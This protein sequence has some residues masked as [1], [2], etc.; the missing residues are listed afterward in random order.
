M[1]VYAC[2]C[3][4]D[5]RTMQKTFVTSVILHDIHHDCQNSFQGS[6]SVLQVCKKDWF[7]NL[8][9]VGK[10][11]KEKNVLKGA[12]SENS[13]GINVLHWMRILPQ[14]SEFDLVTV[15]IIDERKGHSPHYWWKKGSQSTFLRKERTGKERCII[16]WG[17]YH[18]KVNLTWS[19]ST[20]LRKEREKVYTYLRILPQKSEFDPVA[21]HIIN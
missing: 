14:K 2:V 20:L 3:V 9:K 12:W 18:R 16:F 13:I 21:V 4:L 19:Q 17:F 11:K 8:E 10:K 15:H 1:C 5:Q 7:L 6:Y